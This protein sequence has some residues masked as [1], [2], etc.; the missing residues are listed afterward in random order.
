MHVYVC[1]SMH[2]CECIHMGVLVFMCVC[3]DSNLGMNEKL[4]LWEEERG[5]RGGRGEED[6][7]E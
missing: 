3:A 1:V 6:L 2:V 7:R 5:I 4:C